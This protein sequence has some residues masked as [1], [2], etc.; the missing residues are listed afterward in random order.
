MTEKNWSQFGHNALF[1]YRKYPKRKK[2]QT[3]LS[4][5]GQ[6]P[7]M[8]QRKKQV[9]IQ[10]HNNRTITIQ[11]H[12]NAN[13]EQS[14]QT[15]PLMWE[16]FST[17]LGKWDSSTSHDCLSKSY[18]TRRK[19]LLQQ[20]SE[21]R[22]RTQM[23]RHHDTWSFKPVVPNVGRELHRGAIWFLWGGIEADWRGLGPKLCFSS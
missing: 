14:V 12:N 16:S 3:H 6:M 10:S 17:W 1:S 18:E 7:E 4:C 21:Y 20:G 15:R 9:Q 23:K 2:W 8:S 11:S 22:R 13:I 5:F 19:V